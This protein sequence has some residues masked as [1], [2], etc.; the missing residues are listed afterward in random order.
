MTEA[1]HEE[2]ERLEL[3]KL[4]QADQDPRAGDTKEILQRLNNLKK[5]AED[6]PLDLEFK[7][8]VESNEVP[9]DHDLNS[10]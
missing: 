2:W 3:L 9:R 7:P 1:S 4:R 8:S 6:F 5:T 10:F